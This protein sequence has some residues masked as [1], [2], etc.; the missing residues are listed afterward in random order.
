M[1]KLSLVPIIC[2]VVGAAHAT[3][4]N[5]M[6]LT[7]PLYEKYS[8]GDWERF[9]SDLKNNNSTDQIIISDVNFKMRLIEDF[10]QAGFFLSYT[11]QDNYYLKRTVRPIHSH[12]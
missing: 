5:V 3:E 6:N 7:D 11:R 9:F 12:F 2:L 10:G 8:G 1:K 4:K